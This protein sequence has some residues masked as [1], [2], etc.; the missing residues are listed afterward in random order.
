MTGERLIN[1]ENISGRELLE[2]VNLI[3]VD[4]D[5]VVIHSGVTAVEKLK[6]ILVQELG[7][8]VDLNFTVAE[9]DHYDQIRTWAKQRGLAGKRLEGIE[10]E[11][12]DDD[13][14]LNNADP[15]NGAIELIQKLK[16]EN[17]KTVEFHTSRTSGLKNITFEWLLLRVP[18]I[19][20]SDLTTA[21]DLGVGRYEVKPINVVRKAKE[22]GAVLVIEDD[23]VHAERILELADKEGVDVWLILIPYARIAANDDL[24]EDNRLLLIE[25]QDESQGI[26]K[27]HEYLFD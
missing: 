10:R 14:V 16:E 13:G 22:Y 2:R 25:R 23:P 11:I 18:N 9:V 5:A 7:A 19:L 24:L 1:N 17:Q 3:L 4:L 21:E 27:L 26:W 8:G 20:E 15:I 6:D 12:W